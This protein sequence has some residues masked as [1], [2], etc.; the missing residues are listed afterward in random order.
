MREAGQETSLR[1]KQL[2]G[3]LELPVKLTLTACVWTVG[4][5]P[6]KTHANMGRTRKVHTESRVDSN[7]GSSHREATAL[8]TAPTVLHVLYNPQKQK[9]TQKNVHLVGVSLL[10]F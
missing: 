8:T 6:Q 2:I 10:Y 4:G 3:I 7:L 9:F 1:D 5:N